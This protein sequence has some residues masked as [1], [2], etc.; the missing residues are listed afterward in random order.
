MKI[1]RLIAG[2][3]GL[4]T[5]ASCGLDQLTHDPDLALTDPNA[6]TALEEAAEVIMSRDYEALLEIGYPDPNG[7]PSIAREPYEDMIALLPEGQ[8]TAELFYS[9][10]RLAVVDN[11]DFIGFLAQFDLASTSGENTLL[12]IV[13]F[14]F[15]GECC[16]VT[17]VSITPFDTVPSRSNAFTFENKGPLHYV[18]AFL[19]VFLPVFMLV[20]AIACIMNKKMPRGWKFAWVPFI[21]IALWG[22]DFNW[23]TGAWQLHLFSVGPTDFQI[24][25]LKAQFLGVGIAKYGYFQ[26]W[27]ISIGSPIGALCYWIYGRRGPKVSTPEEF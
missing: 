14:P 24:N 13:V 8:L 23:T 25:F 6:R 26:P 15:E 27:I 4:L 9:E 3:F 16:L 12:E 11:E 22:Y 21:L 20:T 5:L 7:G 17:N 1:Y 18:T 2:L 19:L 10:R